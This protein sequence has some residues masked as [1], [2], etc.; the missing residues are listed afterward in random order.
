MIT[1]GW[2]S[3]LIS[4]VLVSGTRIW[5]YAKLLGAPPEESDEPC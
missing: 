4:L 1:W 3:M 2:V 5:G